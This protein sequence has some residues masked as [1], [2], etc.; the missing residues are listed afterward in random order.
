MAKAIRF[1]VDSREPLSVHDYQSL[2]HYRS[3]LGGDIAIVPAGSRDLS[4]VSRE[5]PAAA[6]LPINVRAT[7][8]WWLH[9]PA[10]RNHSILRGEVLLVGPVSA[11]GEV[12]N[13]PRA[14]EEC[15]L[16]P[17]GYV[18]QTREPG[19]SRWH[20]KLVDLANYLD[21]ATEALRLLVPGSVVDEVRV[22][23]RS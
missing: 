6:E 7:V 10:V 9:L 12:R 19:D 11:A 16:V 14:V 8:L 4:F 21:A 18:I 2:T 20:V 3:A 13:L 22:V 15:L 17:A 5:D 1:P 23:R